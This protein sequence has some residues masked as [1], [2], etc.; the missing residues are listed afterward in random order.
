MRKREASVVTVQVGQCGNQVGSAL[1]DVLAHEASRARRLD[2]GRPGGEAAVAGAYFCEAAAEAPLPMTARAVLVDSEPKVVSACIGAAARSPH[3]WRY[4]AAG[5]ACVAECG[6]G[7]ANNWAYGYHIHGRSGLRDRVRESV[8]RQVEACDWFEG[9]LVVQSAAGG[10][11][12]GL[13]SALT[14][15]LR[16]D[17]G[18]ATVANVLVWPYQCGEVIV[19]NYNAVLTLANVL[20]F[21]D[22][23]VMFENTRVHGICS[24]SLRMARP[25]FRQLNGVIARDL[26]AGVLLPATSYSAA[27]EGRPNVG[28]PAAAGAAGCAAGGGGLSGVLGDLCAHPAYK[29]VGVHSTPQEPERSRA[30]STHSWPALLK[31]L[32]QDC[33]RSAEA[34]L[35]GRLVLRGQGAA[36]VVRSFYAAGADAGIGAD[37]GGAGATSAAGRSGAGCGSGSGSGSGSGRRKRRRRRGGGR[38]RRGCGSARR[39]RRGSRGGTRG[40]LH[41]RVAAICDIIFRQHRR[42]RCHGVRGLRNRRIIAVGDII[43]AG[44]S[45]S[46]TFPF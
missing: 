43:S 10:T 17:Y 18:L 35:H 14:A 39:F 44:S 19:Q 9:F 11:G 23:V 16:D 40:V 38:H 15:A 12:S 13:G 45:T 3:N 2:A 30:F 7:S 21:S 37:I 33:A 24:G 28:R 34:T 46:S 36:G 5:A 31:Q 42:G 1:F 25:A 8:R 29:L 41:R 20:P 4:D 22:S 32:R 27:A 26:A 6:R